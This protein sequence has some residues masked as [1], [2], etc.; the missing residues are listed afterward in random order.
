MVLDAI[1]GD[2]AMKK[3][4]L[5]PSVRETYSRNLAASLKLAL[6]TNTQPR[7]RKT[8]ANAPSSSHAP[9]AAPPLRIDPRRSC[10]LARPRESDR[11]EARSSYDRPSISWQSRRRIT[12][13]LSENASGIDRLV[14]GFDFVLLTLWF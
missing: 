7:S 10:G 1:A 13:T 14:C 8:R 6:N 11:T 12:R 3:Y 5:L 2:P 4:H 9:P